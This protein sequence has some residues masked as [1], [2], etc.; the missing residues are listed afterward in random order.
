M[1]RLRNY[2]GI[3][4]FIALNFT[5]ETR[6]QLAI[7]EVMAA[8]KANTNSA[9]SGAEYWELTNLITNDISCHGYGFRDSDHGRPLTK[10]PFTNLLIHAAESII[11]FRI[12]NTNQAVT[13]LAGFRTWWGDSGLPANLN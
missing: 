2:C 7:T 3:L 12:E 9:F 11:F 6:A 1:R 4:V 5:P 10:E 13:S 8:P